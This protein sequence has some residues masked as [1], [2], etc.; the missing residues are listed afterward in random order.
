MTADRIVVVNGSQHGLVALLSMLA[1]EGDV[2]L[3]EELTYP[4]LKA[5]AGLLRLRLQGWR[6]DAQGIVPEALDEACR[7]PARGVLYCVPTIHNPIAAVMGARRRAAIAEVVR[8]HRLTPIEDDVH[9]RLAA[10]PPP[11]LA[12][13]VPESTYYVDEHLEDP[14]PRAAGRVRRRAAG[15]GRAP[16]RH[17]ARHHVGRG[18]ADHRDRGGLDPR[19]HRGVASWPRDASEAAARQAL[20]ARDARRLGG[21]DDR[22]RVPLWMT[23]PARVA[24]RDLRRRGRR[25]GVAVTPADAFHVGRAEAPSAVRLCLGAPRTREALARGLRAV[26]RPW[27]RGRRRRS[28]SSSAG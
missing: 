21:R 20:V 5:I 7:A 18:A 1:R 12:A 13:L 16:G 27:S 26:R 24:Q 8:R 28:R 11:P 2:V 9:G 17:R 10:N 4:G 22:G 23:L 25:R 14:R 6:M 15:H 3:A 19:R